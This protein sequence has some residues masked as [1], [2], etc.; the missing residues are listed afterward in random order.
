M[1]KFS[2]NLYFLRIS[3]KLS[4]K[5]LADKLYVSNKTVSKWERGV[6]EPDLQTLN[7]IAL[8]FNVSVDDL[9]N[10]DMGGTGS[11]CVEDDSSRLN[12]L[13]K[14]SVII[15]VLLVFGY[16]LAVVCYMVF[17][18][19]DFIFN[20]GYAGMWVG[21]IAFIVWA[22]ICIAFA[23]KVYLNYFK[24]IR[25]NDSKTHERNYY[26]SLFTLCALI[27]FICTISFFAQST[28]E[29]IWTFIL[30]LIIIVLMA[31]LAVA[32][33]FITAFIYTAY[34]GEKNWV[35]AACGMNVVQGSAVIPVAVLCV[36]YALHH[37]GIAGYVALYV[38][39]G[40]LALVAPLVYCRMRKTGICAHTVANYA[41]NAVTAGL[42][43]LLPWLMISREDMVSA[44]V[45]SCIAFAVN[46]GYKIVLCRYLRRVS[47]C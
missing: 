26:R 42:V 16:I 1:N 2:Q 20:H 15:N 27:V 33:I 44:L 8:C 10:K 35:S 4:Q 12:V 32:V 47:E 18:T 37:V 14:R 43:T 3:E 5:E 25:K 19:R 9:L 40:I 17:G 39:T 46:V 30:P 22:V 23:V 31:A 24:E 6:C 7:A 11:V 45:V 13:A 36:L 41:V 38:L 21:V 34:R 28:A 29:N